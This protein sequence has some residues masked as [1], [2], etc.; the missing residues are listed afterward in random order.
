[1]RRQLPNILTS[2]R[3]AA[4]P[5]L[6]Y[7]AA[8]G[9]SGAFAALLAAS[10]IGDVLDGLLARALDAT[11]ARGAQL[12]SIADTLLFFIT[13]VGAWVFHQA[14]VRAHAEVFA[15]VPIVWFAENALA[16][17]RYGRLSSFHTYLSRAA[18]V[19]MSLFVVVLFAQGLHAGL[20]AAA[21]TLVMAATIEECV[22]LW[23]LPEWTADV[24]GVYWV[25][26]RGGRA[27]ASGRR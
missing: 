11:S 16:L 6:A 14:D 3:I 25:L 17:W 21:V 8:I 12:D 13:L 22:L 19:A 10:L 4:I 9:A 1:M 18:A 23:L 7:F 5:A 2:L 20:L 15:L 27:E 24:R 26:R